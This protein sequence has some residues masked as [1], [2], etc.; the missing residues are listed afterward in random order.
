MK[1]KFIVS[2]I[3]V[4]LM[5]LTII[6]TGSECEASEDF[7]N[8]GIGGATESALN[9]HSDMSEAEKQE[10]Y[11]SLAAMPASEFNETVGKTM[12]NLTDSEKQGFLAWLKASY[13]ICD[14]SSSDNWQLPTDF[15][16]PESANWS[17][18]IPE[19]GQGTVSQSEQSEDVTR[20]QIK[21][22][23]KSAYQSWEAKF[24]D[25]WS[26]GCAVLEVANEK[27]AEAEK[28][29]GQSI[30][31]SF[32]PESKTT[33]EVY[34]EA[35]RTQSESVIFTNDD[36]SKWLELTYG[37]NMATVTW[38]GDFSGTGSAEATEEKTDDQKILEASIEGFSI[39]DFP[40][41][42][43]GKLTK[44][45]PEGKTKSG[46]PA[47]VLLFEGGTA[48]STDEWKERFVNEG[49]KMDLYEIEE[50]NY[51]ETEMYDIEGTKDF[52][53]EVEGFTYKENN[54]YFEK[55]TDDNKV[56]RIL[57]TTIE[58]SY[59][60]GDEVDRDSPKYKQWVIITVNE[61]DILDLSQP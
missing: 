34:S 28:H 32:G 25:Q 58:T 4:G 6:M 52:Y 2:L 47:Q 54:V 20:I 53:P 51:L 3:L 44:Y 37:Q 30:Q 7:L 61:I 48:Q 10:M 21:N 35:G 23:T 41:P 18:G 59:G 17:S 43:A 39:A 24:D 12:K 57:M 14:S 40:A 5:L 11:A 29:V 31:G 45:T 13:L 1:K 15:K 56:Q 38:S 22:I 42:S 50:D 27:L 26:L 36:M 9:Y 16:V 55:A 33:E 46:N 19:P 60:L 8:T 49:W